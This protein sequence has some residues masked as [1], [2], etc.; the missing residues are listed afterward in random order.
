MVEVSLFRGLNRYSKYPVVASIII[1]LSLSPVGA[2]FVESGRSEELN[3]EELYSV[4]AP[5]NLE[6]EHYGTDESKELVENGTFPEDYEPW[7]L[8]REVSEGDTEARWDEENY[9]EGG[10]IYVRAEKEG[11]EDGPAIEEA[12]WEQDI[13]PISEEITVNA[14]YRKNIDLD[15][16]N[17]EADTIIELFVNDTEKG[18][19]MIYIDEES[20]EVDDPE[21]LEFGPDATYTPVGEVNAVRSYMH[22]EVQGHQTGPNARTAT[23]ELWM[24]NISITTETN[25][26]EDNLLTWDA[27]PDD[28][29]KITSYNIYR[30]EEKGGPYEVIATVD[31]DGSEEYEYIDEGKGTADETIW[32]YKVS[33][34]DDDEDHE[35]EATDE[36]QEPGPQPPTNPIP[37]DGAED[38]IIDPESSVNLSVNVSHTEGEIV[39]NVTF[40]DYSD[41]S[42]IGTVSDVENGTRTDNVTWDNLEAGETYHW[43]TVAE[44]EGIG[45]VTS[46]TWSFTTYAEDPVVETLEAQDVTTDSATLRGDVTSLGDYDSVE[47]YFRWQEDGEEEWTET[48]L[49]V[50][51]AVG[52][53]DESITDLTPDTL[54]NFT[55]VIEYNTQKLEGDVQNFTTFS[56]DEIVV[57]L[58]A[59]DVTTSSATLRGEVTDL[60]GYDEVEAFFDW[61]ENGEVDWDRVIVGNLTDPGEFDYELTELDSD[62]E[63]GFRAGVKY[64]EDEDTGNI[65]PFTTDLM[66]PAIETL[67]AEEVTTDSAILKGKVTSL[68]DYEKVDPYFEWQVA[69]EDDWTRVDLDTLEEAGVFDHDLTGLNSDTEYEFRAGVEF[70]E[71]KDVGD[72]VTFTTLQEATFELENLVVDPDEV[73]INEEFTVEVD[74]QNVGDVGGTYTAEFYDEENGLIGTDEVTVE[75]GE[76]ETASIT[77]SIDGPAEY[78]IS[79][80]GLTTEIIVSD[81]PDVMTDEATDIGVN[82]ARMQGELIGIGLED[83]VKAYFQI[84]RGRWSRLD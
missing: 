65:I 54:H 10:S 78:E 30:S 75:A 50:V 58:E 71:D 21:W 36:V 12:Y 63:Y 72:I 61:R 5:T 47:T 62:T 7:E 44:E 41:D 25:R 31:S 59:Q 69:E 77:H 28:P 23:G 55:A 45:N 80:E 70:K 73:Y 79:V 38:V 48:D 18:W 43:Y 35:S 6:V 15:T 33:A 37:E 67:E 53:F 39:D 42:V 1:I 68:G 17:C 20:E 19:Q 16:G 29:D 66:D 82:S 32:W 83:E 3:S 24:D 11:E 34:V 26:T 52:V 22:V 14:A 13:G 4:E 40:Y 60:G 51:D 49:Q 57:T 9:S 46:S 8:T 74:V 27:S 76:T 2:Y 84:S 56:D 81:Y 64:N